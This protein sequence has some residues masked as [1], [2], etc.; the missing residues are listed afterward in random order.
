MAPSKQ[1]VT[2]VPATPPR[3]GLLIAAETITDNTSRWE[4][5]GITWDPEQCAGGGVAAVECIGN[6]SSLVIPSN[7]GLAEADPFLVWAGDKC[8][9]IGFEAREYEGRARRLL[10][11]SQSFWVANEFWTGDLS[12]AEGLDNVPLADVASDTV[13]TTEVSV[14]NALGLLE[15][16]LADCGQGA[17]GMIHVTS[18]VLLHAVAERAV[19]LVGQQYMTPLG[20]IVVGDAGYPGTGPNGE[21]AL[22]TQ[23]AYATSMVQVRLAP[24][25]I[26]PGTFDQAL[27]QMVERSQNTIEIRVQRLALVQW[28]QCCHFSAEI[29][30]PTPAI[31]GTS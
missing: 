24:V 15:G 1:A 29:N 18:Q 31:A 16:A 4:V 26:V 13:T 17:R 20:T 6:T 12:T 21:A 30:L 25:M 19:E 5:G 23:W 3:Y 10:D 2:A 27:A 28:D 7:P 22:T 11:A 14:L 9:T 8:S